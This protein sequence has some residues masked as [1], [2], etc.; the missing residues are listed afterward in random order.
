MTQHQF[1]AQR[2]GR[3]QPSPSMA[4]NALVSELRKQGRDIINFTI[5]EPDFDT[6]R[7]VIEAAAAAMVRGDTHYTDSSGT[8]ALRKAIVEKLS[9]DNRLD[10]RENEIVAG[11]GGKHI[12][13]HALAATLNPGDEVIV[14]TPYWVS[15]PDIAVLNEATPVII[16]GN[17]AQG[18]KLPPQE[19]EAAITPRTKWVILNSPNNPSGAVY[20]REELAALA[21]VLRRHPQ[22]L[23]MSDEIY[24]HFVYNESQHLSMVEVAPDLKERV[25]IVNG[26]SKGYAMTGWRLG[27]GAGPTWLIQAITKLITQTTTCPSSVSQAASVAAFA[28]DQA[29]VDEMRQTYAARRGRVLAL[30][31]DIPGLTCTPPAGAFYVF[32]SVAGVIGK[33][34]PDGKVLQSDDDVVE[35]L[36]KEEGVATVS[37]RA[38]GM[39]PYIRL[40][41]ASSMDILEEGCRRI[42]LAFAKLS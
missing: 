2:L 39:S 10:Y 17:E 13:Y 19:L 5:G 32:P 4:A 20:S 12:I 35:Y 34:T 29:P 30:L 37:G 26:A 3:I 28:G 41:F 15:Y 42:A 40:S 27:F 22:V 9:R 7:H 1:L 16:P 11:S 31:K 38:Y 21:D 36:L 33:A 6:P 23:I 18:F 25:L 14:H 24:E 8:L